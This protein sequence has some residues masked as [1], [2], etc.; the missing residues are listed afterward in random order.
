MARTACVPC[1]ARAHGRVARVQSARIIDGANAR[2]PSSDASN[3]R[4]RPVVGDERHGDGRH[5]D[6]R[7][8]VHSCADA[9][10]FARAARARTTPMMEMTSAAA[11]RWRLDDALYMPRAARDG[12]RA[13]SSSSSD[14]PSNAAVAKA[15]WWSATGASGAAR[16]VASFARGERDIAAWSAFGDF[17]H[18]GS[19]TCA[20]EL[21]EGEETE[22]V[23]AARGDGA[24]NDDGT[25]TN[26]GRFARLSGSISSEIPG[27]ASARLKRSGFAG[28]RT[29]HLQPTMLNPDPVLD[30]DAF[31]ALSYRV[32]GCGRMYIASVRTENWM[33]GD[34][35]EDVWQAAFT[36]PANKWVDIVIPLDAF[37]QTYRGRA[38]ADHK[39]MSANRVVMLGVAVAGSAASELHERAKLDG[40]YTLDIHSIIGLRM[41]EDEIERAAAK[42][43][44]AAGDAARRQRGGF[45][46]F[47][48]NLNPETML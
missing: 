30:L 6:E 28:V 27:G 1:A 8:R 41:S 42:I 14:A 29:V 36:P 40:T 4:C 46:A 48:L 20:F 17:E 25:G 18:G 32:R 7:A 35:T 12:T 45:A 9:E 21:I 24:R 2:A 34:S 33:T 43:R 10:M 47:A 11:A 13:S 16:A 38:M 44:D 5:G 31:E 39:R 23:D 37:T 3:R 26:E 19:S 15:A 22:G